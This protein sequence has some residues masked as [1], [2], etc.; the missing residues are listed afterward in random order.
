MKKLLLFIAAFLS[1]SLSQQ[2]YATDNPVKIELKLYSESLLKG[3]SWVRLNY[4]LYEQT[5]ERNYL[6][7]DSY[8]FSNKDNVATS[9]SFDNLTS[10]FRVKQGNIFAY[11]ISEVIT[12]KEEII[13]QRPLLASTLKYSINPFVIEDSLSC[14]LLSLDNIRK[15][16]IYNKNNAKVIAY[17]SDT[18]LILCSPRSIVKTTDGLYSYYYEKYI[19]KKYLSDSNLRKRFSTFNIQNLWK[20]NVGKIENELCSDTLKL[21]IQSWLN[22]NLNTIPSSY[23]GNIISGNARF[24]IVF[25]KMGLVDSVV[26]YECLDKELNEY[27]TT[28]VKQI[29]CVGKLHNDRDIRYYAEPPHY[30]FQTK[31]IFTITLKR[32]KNQTT[33]SDLVGFEGIFYS[34]DG[35][36]FVEEREV[37]FIND[38][39][40]KWTFYN[41]PSE[42]MEILSTYK[43]KQNTQDNAT[44][45]L[46]SLISIKSFNAQGERELEV[47]D[48]WKLKWEEALS[49]YIS[50]VDDEMHVLRVIAYNPNNIK[51]IG[52]LGLLHYISKKNTSQK[53]INRFGHNRFSSINY[54]LDKTQ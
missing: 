9:L 17:L 3:T 14:S 53:I 42:K 33:T 41:K 43:L 36:K 18:L 38:T 20:R 13:A 4:T 34:F 22:E 27:I 11:R 8:S 1:L 29:P 52:R 49:C 48:D 21:N 28:I 35:E 45:C 19:N 16:E 47:S 6:Q 44:L 46:I 5:P 50:F 26:F 10:D 23:N 31:E 12:S 32:I 7:Y 54:I 37:Y 40:C 25:N 15:D 2:S 24:K 30:K 51:Y 39:L